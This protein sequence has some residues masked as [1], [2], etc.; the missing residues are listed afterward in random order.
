MDLNR[1]VYYKILSVD[2]RQN[3]SL[4]SEAVQVEKPD[5]V[6]PTPPQ[7]LQLK[8]ESGAILVYYLHSPSMDVATHRLE[9]LKVG[10]EVWNLFHDF[11]LGGPQADTAGAYY[12]YRDSTV[13]AL[14]DYR[15]RLTAYDHA[16]NK[17][18]SN[19]MSG[20]SYD[21][22]V[23]GDINNGTITPINLPTIDATAV[24]SDYSKG[25]LIQWD[26][27]SDPTLKDFVIYR[28]RMGEPLRE[29]KTLI[30]HKGQIK[31]PTYVRWAFYQSNLNRDFYFL[32]ANLP[33][34]GNYE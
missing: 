2:N 17:S 27:T 11:E 30:I 9:S 16:G 24:W 3:E 6:P 31:N 19:I 7:I 20:R 34:S 25:V 32:D 1:Y 8:P 21:D 23:R 10:E 5:I 14:S 12:I 26:Y 15:Y 18:V 13:E 4:M 33:Q 22:G 28:Q 29:I